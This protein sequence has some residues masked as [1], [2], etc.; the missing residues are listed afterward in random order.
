MG[1]SITSIYFIND[2]IEFVEKE[3]K[4][5][6]RIKFD[7]VDRTCL[8]GGSSRNKGIDVADGEIICYLDTDDFIGPPHL[9]NISDNFT[10]KIDWCF[11]NDYV[12]IGNNCFKLR[13]VNLKEMRIG[14]CSI[15]HKKDLDI[16][17]NNGYGHDHEIIKEMIKKE[18]KFK[19]IKNSQYFICHIPV[20]GNHFNI[21][22][23]NYCFKT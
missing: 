9:K 17:W 13:N 19:K 5:E 2:Q 8:F 16:R 23:P 1:N 22:K 4:K 7:R 12:F 11:Y 3:F 15:A 14:T 10:N 18:Y 21:D 6:D 20:P